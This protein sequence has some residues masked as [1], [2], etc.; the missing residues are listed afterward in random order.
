MSSGRNVLY[1]EDQ[2]QPLAKVVGATFVAEDEGVLALG[3]DTAGTY[4]AL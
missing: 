1:E 3:I 2:Q 4:Q